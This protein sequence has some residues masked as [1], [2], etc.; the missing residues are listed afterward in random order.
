VEWKILVD[1]IQS[2]NKMILECVY[3]TFCSI[4]A[5]DVRW[6]QLEVDVFIAEELLEE[7]GTLIVEALESWAEAYQAKLLDVEDLV[8]GENRVGGGVHL[9]WLDKNAVRVIIIEDE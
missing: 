9:H 7:L 4:A 2:H 8:C 5:M 1:A 3:H 6:N